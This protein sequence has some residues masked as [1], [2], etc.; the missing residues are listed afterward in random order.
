MRFKLILFCLLLC[1]LNVQAQFSGP[2]FLEN[3][4][5]WP[6]HVHAAA[7]MGRAECFIAESGWTYRLYEEDAFEEFHEYHHH[8]EGEVPRLNGHV[9]KVELIGG[10]LKVFDRILAHDCPTNIL[11]KNISAV[12]LQ[13]FSSYTFDEVYPG[14]DLLWEDDNGSLKYSFLVSTSGDEDQIQLYWKGQDA[15]SLSEEGHLMVTTSVGD[16]VEWQ[17]LVYERINGENVVVPSRYLIHGDT[18]SFH[19]ERTAENNELIIDPNVVF[20]SYS[21]ASSDNWGFTATYDNLGKLYLGGVGFGFGFPFSP[22]AF[23]T[24]YAGAM[25]VTIMKFS[26][27]GV[28]REYATWLG[29]SRAEQPHSLVVDGEDLIIFG[30][31]GSDDF[32][33]S[34]TAYDTTFNGG[35]STPGTGA[36]FTIGSDIFV[37]KLNGS[38][39]QLIGSTYLGGTGNDGLNDALRNNYGDAARGEVNIDPD[40][41]ILV[42]STTL[43]ADFPETI[44]QAIKGSQDAIV[45]KL[46]PDLSQLIW[47]TILGGIEEDAAF[48]T[49]S[50]NG[51]T[52]VSGTTNANT[53]PTTSDSW[54]PFYFGGF[55]DGF[56]TA[57]NDS[58]RVVSSTFLGS[59]LRDFSFFLFPDPRGRIAVLGQTNGN[60]PM[61]EPT[62]FGDST[63]RQ[64]LQLF[65]PQLDTMVRS[66][67]I[68]SDRNSYDFSP[69]AFLIDSCGVTY[70]SG[71][72]GALNPGNGSVDGLYISNDAYQSTTDG[73][74]FYLIAIDANW[75][76]PLYGTFFGG[77]STGEH[78]DGGTSRFS[79]DGIISQ[80]V[81]AGCGGTDGTPAFPSNAWSTSNGSGNCN[82]LGF[83]I[84]F[85]L[86]TLDVGVRLQ[87]DTICANDSAYFTLELLNGDSLFWDY[88]DGRTYS[89]FEESTIFPNPGDFYVKVS[90]FNINCLQ[91]D[92]DSVLIHVVSPTG[93]LELQAQF[94]ECDENLEVTFDT[95]GSAD[96]FLLYTGTGL[97][98]DSVPLTIS[99]PEPGEYEAY[100]V[101]SIG[102]CLTTQFDTVNIEFYPLPSPISVNLEHVACQFPLELLVEVDKDS[103]ST[104]LI[105]YGDGQLDSGKASSWSHI[106]AESG[107]YELVVESTDSLCQLKDTFRTTI[108]IGQEDL[109]QLEFPNVF[110]PN[111]DGRNDALNFDVMLNGWDVAISDLKVYNRWGSEVYSGPANWDGLCESGDC[112]EGVYFWIFSWE[113]SCGEKRGKQGFVH[114]MR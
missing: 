86:D 82:M 74:D 34:P 19:V 72:G 9:L 10:K 4:G 27:D 102:G 111:G 69:S 47:S 12:G 76:T 41:N 101:Y 6:D 7:P 89:G 39:S 45:S 2:G 94:D 20:S 56:L 11:R 75:Q 32:P 62:I 17:P 113:N 80:A 25:E 14:I 37:T 109:G 91:K 96:Y 38:G 73:N 100:I 23:D 107:V 21:G 57:L 66:T 13:T 58:G 97:V 104:L 31:T 28:N 3:G 18:V 83:K 78:V 81:C 36:T 65:S 95:I 55:S 112:K 59:F 35:S 26:A 50:V 70:I 22:G 63:S 71:W 90:A 24:I 87:A 52:Y 5:Q 53:F 64:F 92:S 29:G 46:N 48:S 61:D 30:A 84:E 68:G 60:V 106:Y 98:L 110:T 103:S 105:D 93:S 88:G 54:S 85:N 114:L 44:N 40:G 77:P 42:A 16:L 99:Y 15:L 8:K 79:P 43:S 51:L 108:Q 33:V 67:R 1:S 49:A